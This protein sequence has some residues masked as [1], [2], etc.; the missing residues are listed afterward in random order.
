MKRTYQRLILAA[1]VAALVAYLNVAQVHSPDHRVA[2]ALEP[3]PVAPVDT[4]DDLLLPADREPLV[5]SDLETSS[6]GAIEREQAASPV[7][8]ESVAF[9]PFV[10]PV[11][12]ESPGAD[13]YVQHLDQIWSQW[14]SGDQEDRGVQEHLLVSLELS[15]A[16]VLNQ[17]GRFQQGASRSQD[18]T[19]A[20]LK[21]ALNG[22]SYYFHEG[23]FP[24]YDELLM[25]TRDW[26]PESPGM[27][28]GLSGAVAA[29][30]T[31]AKAYLEPAS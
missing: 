18:A 29:R 12:P 9:T 2:I 8:E 15:I 26:T 13:V 17:L 31:E 25:S 3:S 10:P 11:Q 21:F 20:P 27:P 22:Y 7:P 1:P 23:E 24:E 30:L 6:K 28:P 5:A 4:L 16:V 19:G 14:E